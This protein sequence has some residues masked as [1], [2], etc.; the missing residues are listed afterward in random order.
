M[1]TKRRI[2]V[3]S[4]GCAACEETVAMVTRLTCPSCD[5]AVLDMH[6]PMVATRAK[7]YGVTRVPA[8]VVDGQLA[9]CCTEPARASRHLKR[10]GSARRGPDEFQWNT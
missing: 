4:A 7:G 8:V 3:F 5:V 2:E 1:S 6:D 10:P 9:G